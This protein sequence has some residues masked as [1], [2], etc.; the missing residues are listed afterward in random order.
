MKINLH[1]AAVAEYGHSGMRGRD[2]LSLAFHSLVDSLSSKC[3][4]VTHSSDTSTLYASLNIRG[5]RGT[6]SAACMSWRGGEGTS[7]R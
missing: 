2:N 5:C 4:Y 3:T 1:R 6:G 7:L